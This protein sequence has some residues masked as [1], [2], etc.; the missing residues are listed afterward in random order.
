MTSDTAADFAFA[1]RFVPVYLFTRVKGSRPMTYQCLTIGMMVKAKENG[2]F[3][4]Q[5]ELK[6]AEQT[7]RL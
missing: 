5:T 2:G 6:I 3:S 7:V 1:T 4:D